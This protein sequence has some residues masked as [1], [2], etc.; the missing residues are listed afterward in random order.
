MPED[1]DVFLSHNSQD[2]EAV[3]TVGEAL[4]AHGVSVWLDSWELR[5]GRRWQRDLEAAVRSSSG[6]AV[7]VGAQGLGPWE[8]PEMEVFLNRAVR[9][10]DLPVIPVL[11]PGA[12]QDVEL[13]AFL[14]LYTWV[15]LRAGI[16]E[17]GIDR[18]VWG[19]TGVRPAGEGSP[20]PPPPAPPRP[21]DPRL[22][23]PE[24]DPPGADGSPKNGP[25]PR[26]WGWISWS[27]LLAVLGLVVAV[28][29]WQCPQPPP[30]TGKDSTSGLPDIYALRVQVLDPDGNPITESQVRVS[31]ANE[32][33]SLPDGWW[34]VEI[35]AIK[36]PLDRK[37]TIRV[38]SEAWRG[39]RREVELGEDPNPTAEI[40]LL[41]PEST[42]RGLVLDPTGRAVAGA[43]V[44]SQDVP[45]PSVTTDADGRFELVLP[46]PPEARVRVRAE[47][48][49]FSADE[50]YCYTGR[51]SCILELRQ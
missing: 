16:T 41:P 30:A 35:P 34:E 47:E 38:D 46:L 11:L 26:R 32:P 24:P 10:D 37:V 22:S 2:K 39:A 44:T 50:T 51:D 28:L 4:K 14:S 36:L 33:Q 17:E 1:F 8:E 42:L 27:T 21:A 49:G 20:S 7:F 29:S 13:P 9:D 5:P 12:P 48:D 25:G 40:Q 43:K 19:V 6:V 3:T 15:D 18:L 31:H 23:T 45:V